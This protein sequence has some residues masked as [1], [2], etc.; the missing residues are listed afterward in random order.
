LRA[1]DGSVTVLVDTISSVCPAGGAL[2]ASSVP[3][4][5]PPPG[6]LSTIA[7]WPSDSVSLCAMSRA[8]MSVAPPGANGVMMRIGL[9][10]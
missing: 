9:T 6:R 8:R 2:A 10:G 1:S 4:T 5:V 3:M 7:W